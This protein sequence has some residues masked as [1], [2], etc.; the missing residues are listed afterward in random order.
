MS[1]T[2]LEARARAATLQVSSYEVALDLATDR[3]HATFGSRTT[4]RFAATTG[5]T[6][7]EL[8]GARELSVTLNGAR[9]AEDAYDGERIRLQGLRSVNELLVE[10]VLPTVTDGDGMHRFTD[11]ADGETYLSAYLGMD[12]ARK[13]FACF[14]QLDLKAPIGLSVSA[15]PAWTVLANGRPTEHAGGRWRF[16]PTAPIPPNLLV[17]CAGPWHSVRWEHAGLPFGWHARRSLAAELDRDADELRRVTTACF[18]HYTGLFDEPYPFDSYDQAMVPELNWGA[19]EM[20]GCVTFRDELLF[21]SGGTDTERTVRAMIVAHEMAHMWFGDLATM[22]WWEDSWLSESFAD[23]MGFEVAARAAGFPGTWVAF[24]VSAKPRAYRCDARRSTH[25]VAAR[26]EDVVDVDTGF[27]NFDQITYA[28][29][30]AVLRQLVTWL[31][32]DAFLA[33]ANDYLSR[34]RFGNAALADFLAALDDATDRDVHGWARAWLQTTGFDTIR[35]TRDGDVPVLVREGLRAH[36]LE[37]AAFRRDGTALLPAGSCFV[38]LADEPVP[39]PGLA[40]LVVVPNSGDHTYARVR[41]DELSQQAVTAGLATIPDPLVRAV[42]WAQALDR[43]R[44]TAATPGEHLRLVA[45]HLPGERH[46][47][48]LDGVLQAVHDE[49]LPGWLEPGE[50]TQALAVVA[51]AGEPGLSAEDPS[52]RLS[53]TRAVARTSVD[54]DRLCGWLRAG[55]TE[56]GLRLD[57]DTRWLVVHRLAGIGAADS[58]MIDREHAR[59]RSASGDLAAARARAALPDAEAKADAWRRMF[60]GEAPSNREFEALADGFWGLEQHELVTAYLDAYLEA[61]PR[62]AARGQATAHAVGSAFPGTALPT[63]TLRRFRER[64]AE[65]VGDDLPTVLRRAWNDRLDDLDVALA[66]RAASR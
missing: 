2:L 51:T 3:S 21:R 34:H 39:L 65:R 47:A 49:L 12:L 57:Q 19:Q 17:V 25:P 38:D 9:V 44:A 27:G 66:I 59:D 52:V 5:E 7:V 30:N 50:V 32:E 24:A 43:V 37:V 60:E 35:C 41:L 13:V 8:T 48:V 11:P 26:T 10:A 29:G 45:R 16:A 56:A 4:I 61:G 42:L 58:G 28:K 14:D 15:D 53:A 6:F 18:D 64:L 40:G 62:L 55:T 1:L 46:P 20:P 33:G 54:A 22:R 63:G 23:Y 31:G 36:R